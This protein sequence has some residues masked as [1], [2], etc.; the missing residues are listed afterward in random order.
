M[1][2]Y[3]DNAATT[4]LDPEVLSA[5]TPY[6]THHFGNP[7]SGHRFGREARQ[8]VDAS[9][10]TIAD[11]LH[12]SPE[13]IYFTSGATESDNLAITGIL[14]T[15]GVRHVITSPLEHHAVL[16]CLEFHQRE[17]NLTVSNVKLRDNGQV[18]LFHLEE[19][20][21]QHPGSLVSLMHAN[22][23]TGNVADIDT[24]GHLCR[25]YGAFF[26]SD[27]VQTLSYFPFNLQRQPVDLL[28]GSA[29]KFHGPK[30]VGLLYVN[31]RLRLKPLLHGGAQEKC[32]RAGT[33][34]VAGIV[35]L[36]KA[37]EI[38][39]R[40]RAAHQRHLLA[41]K[42][43]LVYRLRQQVE[44]IAFNGDCLSAEGGHPAIVNV[45]LP[46]SATEGLLAQLDEAGIAASGGSACT[47]GSGGS[48]VLRQL[49]VDL[50]R[51]N[52]RFSFS[53]YNSLSEIAFVTDTVAGLLAPAG[54]LQRAG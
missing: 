1:N 9:R 38:A 31:R 43:S 15:Y 10:Q 37:L 5:M 47:S 52:V 14:Q 24:I 33:E 20:L 44:D 46:S 45:S 16:H 7:S 49:N 41:L 23:E 29:H 13:E 42:Q 21:R 39:V 30:G 22:N 11:L 34:N 6:L 28:V 18:N 8:A 53:K 54:V 50:S 27:T 12:A 48:H 26:H 4:A 2:V 19:L 17:N 51:N 32:L 36:A 35:G 25:K 40:E 3:L